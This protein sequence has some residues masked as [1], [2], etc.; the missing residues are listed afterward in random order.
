MYHWFVAANLVVPAPNGSEQSGIRVVEPPM[1]LDEVRLHCARLLAQGFS[2]RQVAKAM[3]SRLN[4]RGREDS[5]YS[6]LKRWMNRDAKF[7]DLIYQQAVVSLDLKAPLILGGVAKAAQRGRVDAARLALELTGRHTSHE[8]Q[9][10]N[11]QVVL[12]NIPRPAAAEIVE[13]EAEELE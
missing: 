8:A 3:A 12:Q 1:D 4:G 9:I 6:K 2:P 10:T 13:G 7:R 11:V 5:A